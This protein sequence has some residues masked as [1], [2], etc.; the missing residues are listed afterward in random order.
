MA[1]DGPIFLKPDGAPPAQGDILVQSDLAATLEAI[2][3]DGPRAFYIG[4]IADKIVA[5]VRGAGGVMV[6][7]R[8]RELR[9]GHPQAR[10]RDLSRL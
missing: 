6:R 7:E 8:P 1:L 10:A 4:P 2:G 5:A 9:R 3:R